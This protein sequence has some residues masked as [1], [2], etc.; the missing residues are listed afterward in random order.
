MSPT[1]VASTSLAVAVWDPDRQEGELVVFA[2]PALEPDKSYQLWLFESD[3]PAG[4]S[5]AVF[6]VDPSAAQTRVPFKLSGAGAGEARFKVSL[7]PKGG[8]AAPA[9]PV[10]LASY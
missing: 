6:G 7:E 8:A 2:L 5:V 4:T 3:H 10:V 9:G 1:T